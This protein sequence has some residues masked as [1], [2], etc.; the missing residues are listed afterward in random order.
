MG[1]VGGGKSSQIET[2][3][4]AAIPKAGPRNRLPRTKFIPMLRQEAK[5]NDIVTGFT[6]HALPRAGDGVTRP[7]VA[8][9]YRVFTLHFA[10]LPGAWGLPGQCMGM[11][12]TRK[13]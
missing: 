2:M 3:K 13:A 11:V 9:Y 6:L 8:V 4:Y 7:S 1:K 10:R 5:K 12:K